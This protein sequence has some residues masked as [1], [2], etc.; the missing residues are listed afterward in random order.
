MSSTD[1]LTAAIPSPD[2]DQGWPP[3]ASDEDLDPV[4]VA[5]WPVSVSPAH[6]CLRTSAPWSPR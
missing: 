1:T 4:I 3:T 2:L 5:A 6:P